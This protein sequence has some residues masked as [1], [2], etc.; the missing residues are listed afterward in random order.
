[1]NVEGGCEIWE[2]WWIVYDKVWTILKIEKNKNGCHMKNIYE[3]LKIWEFFNFKLYENFF[4]A[5]QYEQR[6]HKNV[7]KC[8]CFLLL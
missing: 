3:S 1:M 7:W 6:I 4:L 5:R 8:V 2:I